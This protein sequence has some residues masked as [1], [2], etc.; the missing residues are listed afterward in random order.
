MKIKNFTFLFLSFSVFIF[1]GCASTA[2]N[3]QQTSP[4]MLEPQALA[5]FQDIPVPVGFKSLPESSYS[6]ESSG[7]RVG[8]LQYQGKADPEAVVNFYKEQMPMYNWFLL[9]AMEYG[10]RILNFDRENETCIIRLLPKGPKVV[11]TISL[12]PKSQVLPKKAKK[13]LDK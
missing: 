8:V 11:I 4:A 2:K 9:N 12:G 1:L 13:T 10:D 6:F 3:N 7:I 5:R